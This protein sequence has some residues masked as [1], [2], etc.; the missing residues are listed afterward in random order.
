MRWQTKVSE[1]PLA[2]LTG[3]PAYHDG[4]LFVPVSS[5]EVAVAQNPDYECCT[6]RGEVVAIELKSGDEKWRYFTVE[7]SPKQ[8]GTNRNDITNYGP[9]GAPVWSTLTIDEKRNRLY[10]GTGQNYTQPWTL[11]SS[12]IHAIEMST[13]ER[14]WIY[15]GI[16]GDAWNMACS[17]LKVFENLPNDYSHNCPE[18]YGPDFDF[19][20]PPILVPLDNGKDVLIAGQ[21]SG[22]VHALDP[23]N[24]GER[25]WKK[26]VGRGGLLGGIHW[27][28]A[29]KGDI[30]YFPDQDAIAATFKFYS[31]IYLYNTK[32]KLKGKFR[33]SEFQ[34][35]YYAYKNKVGDKRGRVLY[36]DNSTIIHSNRINDKWLLLIV[37]E[38]RDVEFISLKE[39]FRGYEWYAYYAFNT[40]N[41]SIY[42]IGRNKKAHKPATRKPIYPTNYGIVINKDSTISWL[43][44]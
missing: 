1:H 44:I 6:F 22:V 43:S 39:G 26:R 30:N 10:F 33:V 29:A 41:S 13:G 18:E 9:S 36:D 11:E 2:W 3:S 17:R 27:G 14:A 16:E 25:I 7:E 23:D 32:G 35:P 4:T 15:Q 12:A 21:K 5:K 28:M 31:C 8:Q 19:G 42:K 40:N 37:R 20:A 34:Q 38:R 24:N